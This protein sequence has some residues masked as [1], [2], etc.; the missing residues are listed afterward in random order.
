MN[1]TL[2]K[3]QCR[4]AGSM[5]ELAGELAELRP[6]LGTVRVYRGQTKRWRKAGRD[7]LLPALH[8]NATATYD[9]EWMAA[10]QRAAFSSPIDEQDSGDYNDVWLP[11]L[12]QHYG[13]GSRFLDVTADLGVA[14]W[15]A[16]NRSR[17]KEA[18]LQLFFS[19]V[20]TDVV[21]QSCWHES[22]Q[23]VEDDQV[24][25]VI[26]VFDAF[27]WPGFGTPGHADLVA[28]RSLPVGQRLLHRATRLEAQAAY[29]L[30]AAPHSVFGADLV[31]SL[32][33]IITL[34]TTF[35]VEGTLASWKTRDLFPPPAMDPCYASLLNV[36]LILDSTAKQYMHR[37][38]I[39]C[40]VSS[41]DATEISSESRSGDGLEIDDFVSRLHVVD[42]AVGADAQ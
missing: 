12:L 35:R 36:P 28:V 26:Y 10:A 18:K 24:K 20:P 7:S 34:T 22:I 40:Y 27:R 9:T 6:P 17:F 13:P 31:G 29:L 15:F 4:Q 14:L 21:L 5:S 11:A 37:L 33:A 38:K 32:R 19:G 39:P 25:P 41:P 2:Q 42:A 1:L 16:L 23:S 3:T 8:R 30:Y